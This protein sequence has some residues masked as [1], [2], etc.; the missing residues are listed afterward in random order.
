MSFL[1]VSD[2]HPIFWVAFCL[3]S[4]YILP[5]F[6]FKSPGVK[7]DAVAENITSQLVRVGLHPRSESPTC[8]SSSKSFHLSEP[9]FS[10]V[11]KGLKV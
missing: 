9:R 2:L 1:L 5:K 3:Y 7:D 10:H 6:T 8:V 4:H 11:K